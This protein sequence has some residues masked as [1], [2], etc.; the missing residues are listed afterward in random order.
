[1]RPLFR[2][3]ACGFMST[4]GSEFK[5]RDGILVDTGCLERGEWDPTIA[6]WIAEAIASPDRDED[7]RHFPTPILAALTT[8]ASVGGV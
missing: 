8:S 5:R 1:M 3:R 4:L 6:R 2:C 7:A